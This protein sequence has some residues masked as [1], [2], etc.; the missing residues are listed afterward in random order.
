MSLTILHVADIKLDPYSGMGRIAYFWKKA[1][2]EAG[3]QFIHLG[4]ENVVTKHPSEFPGKAFK[5]FKEKFGKKKPDVILAHEPVSGKFIG[6]N[7]PIALFSHGIEQREWNLRNTS[8]K[9]FHDEVSLRSKVLFPIWR[10]RNCNKGLRKANLLLLSNKEDQ[11]YAIE[12]F[13]RCIDDITIF[14]NGVKEDFLTQSDLNIENKECIIGFSAT[15]I[16]RKGT[17]L[18]IEASKKLLRDRI[19]VRWLLFGTVFPKEDILKE[20][21]EELHPN[22][23]IVP[24][25]NSDEEKKL[26]EQ[27]DIFILPSF[28]EGQSLALLQGMAAGLCC[29]TSDNCAQIDLIQHRVNGLLFKTG[30]YI[31]LSTQIELA[32]KN[33]KFRKKLGEN[34][35]ESVIDRRWSVVSKEVVNQIEKIA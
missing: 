9:K 8:Y 23:E 16:K 25:F 1:F 21:P 2:E 30:D 20:F 24:T 17:G 5:I 13:K 27:C 10:L 6:T 12:K 31:D 34:A 33:P 3:H 14:R 32:I 15:W 28:F 26:Y 7:I 19:P 4:K 35:R 29:V 11:N 18:I 22:I